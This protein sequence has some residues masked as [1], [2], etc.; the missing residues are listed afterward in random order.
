MTTNWQIPDGLVFP[1][2]ST[3]DQFAPHNLF[4]SSAHIYNN[5][6]TTFNHTEDPYNYQP[7]SECVDDVYV[8]T[9]LANYRNSSQSRNVFAP[10]NLFHN[11]AFLDTYAQS[12]LEK[13]EIIEKCLRTRT[14]CGSTSTSKVEVNS[15]GEICVICQGEYVNDEIIGTLECGHEY[16]ISC[17][18]KWLLR[19]KKTCPICRSSVACP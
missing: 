5:G 3:R 7:T 6:Q 4:H 18:K 2:N 15:E 1:R 14:Y 17:I 10:H 8:A 19:G 16:H 11:S 13:E 12:S 9:D